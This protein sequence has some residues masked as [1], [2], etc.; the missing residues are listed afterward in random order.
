MEEYKLK[1]LESGLLRGI[2]VRRREARTGNEKTVRRGF[3]FFLSF[4]FRVFLYIKHIFN[5]PTKCTS[6]LLIHVSIESLT[7]VS[8]CYIY[9]L[10]GEPL[11][12]CTGP[13]AL[14]CVMCVYKHN[15]HQAP[16]A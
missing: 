15:Q 16:E 9:H 1:M 14:Y 2:V 5:I 8:A 3:F 11:I 10:Q 12:T 4:P 7:R 13:T 6:L